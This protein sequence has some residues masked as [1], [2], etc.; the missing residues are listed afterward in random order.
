MLRTPAMRLLT[1]AFASATEFLDSYSDAYPSGAVFCGT[2]APVE[3]DTQVLV[4]IHFPELPNRALVRGRVVSLVA[5]SGA[6]VRFAEEDRATCEFL[7]RL[8]RGELTIQERMERTHRRFPAEL[9][10]DCQIEELDE[11]GPD[12][13]LS[14]TQDLGAGGAF[15]RSSSPPAIGTRVC[16][17]I[18]PTSDTG[19]SF[20]IYGRVA[21]ARRDEDQ[22]G[23]GVCFDT[24]AEDHD[25]RRLRALLRRASAT[26]RLQFAVG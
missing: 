15:V 21:W 19:E 7:V 25:A 22:C 16:L 18:G 14:R 17:I 13:L 9:P 10:V 24:R 6:W 2:R 12:R 20:R 3:L 8:A 26:G 11:E 23:F 1:V 4:E 5:R